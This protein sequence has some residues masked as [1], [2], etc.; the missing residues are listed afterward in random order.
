M[1]YTYA[2]ESV[3][4]ADGDTTKM[5]HYYTDGGNAHLMEPR[6][7]FGA[8]QPQMWSHYK[9]SSYNAHTPILQNLICT[10]LDQLQDPEKVMTIV[11]VFIQ[12]EINDEAS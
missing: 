6:Q 8:R 7:P 11:N 3:T 9:T 4:D 1:I 10:L 2:P 12:K 5:W